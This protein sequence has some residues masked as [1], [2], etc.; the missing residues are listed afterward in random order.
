MMRARWLWPVAAGVAVAAVVVALMPRAYVGVFYDDGIYLSLARSLA[1]GHGYRLLYLPGAPPAV[2]YPP[3]YPL[4]LAALWKLWSAFPGNVL[5]FRAANGALLG[6]FAG[7]FAAYLAWRRTLPAG[8]AALAVAVGSTAVP[9]L[10]VATVLFAEPLFLVF[11]VGAWWLGDAARGSAP[12]RRAALLAAAAGVLAGLTALTRSIGIAVVGGVVL[13]LVLERRWRDALLAALGALAL[14]APWTAWSAARSGAV[15]SVLALNYGTYDA[16][17]RQAGWG[18]LSVDGLWEVLRPLGAIALATVRGAW[19]P[20]FGVP[21]LVVLVVGAVAVGRRAPALGWSLACYFGVMLLW[22]YG[23]DRF[24]WAVLPVLLVAMVV[25]TLSLWRAAAVRSGWRRWVVRALVLAGALPVAAGFGR[26]QLIGFVEG[27][28]T[29]AQLGISRTFDHVVPW[30]KSA[31]PS[32]AILATEDEALLW[33]YTGRRAVP[34]FLWHLEGRNARSF[35]PDTLR[36]YLERS[37]ATHVLLTGPRSDAA[38]TLDDLLGRYPGYLR[39]VMMWPG[40]ITAFAV[41]ER[42][43]TDAPPPSR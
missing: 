12:G 10:A 35:G 42:S 14:V 24:L 23:P 38:A 29:S 11:A 30:V 9:L 31:T 40:P 8:G 15:P 2:H 33:L 18:A 26:Y 1:E 32:S 25:G 4:F 3:L 22:P 27:F 13:A 41:M 28:A 43:T 39:I 5:L 20:V 19:R 17:L 21:G 36:A 7:G 34:S 6:L 37:G 16:V